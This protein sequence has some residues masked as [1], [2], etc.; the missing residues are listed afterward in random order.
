M[1][2]HIHF[3]RLLLIL[4]IY[5]TIWIGELYP[6]S[7]S[8]QYIPV[9][10]DVSIIAGNPYIHQIQGDSVTFSTC[11]FYVGN[12]ALI[13]KDTVLTFDTYHLIDIAN[14]ESTLLSLQIPSGF[15]ADSLRFTFGVDSLTNISGA[16]GGDLDPLHGMYWA[17]N[18]GFINMKLEGFSPICPARN[19]RF[20][21]HIGGYQ[22]PYQ[23]SSII[24]LAVPSER[25]INIAVHIDKIIEYLNLDKEYEIMSPGKKARD[26][27][28]RMSKMFSIK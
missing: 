16:M 20:Q 28:V 7:I 1:P 13:N 23:T 21:L 24:T 15:Y 12:Y 17:W 14:I 22:A 19:H 4:L 26:I 11:K 8:L 10:K 18:S 9:Y 5:S 3:I 2:M 27:S 6:Q 25:M